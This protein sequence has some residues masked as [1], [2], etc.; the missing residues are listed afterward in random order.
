V[1]EARAVAAC[2]RGEYRLC[3]VAAGAFRAHAHAGWVGALEQV[4]ASMWPRCSHPVS[5]SPHARPLWR[6][7]MGCVNSHLV[8][9]VPQVFV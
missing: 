8:V 6:R 9:L 5:W 7:G 3:L 1:L 2:L 4:L